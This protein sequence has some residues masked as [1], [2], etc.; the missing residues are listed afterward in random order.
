[1][2][3]EPQLSQG[4]PERALHSSKDDALTGLANQVLLLARLERALVRGRQSKGTVA[5][6][7]ADLDHF[8]TINDV[9]GHTVGDELLSAVAERLTGLIR[10]GDTV[11]RLSGAEFVILCEDLD[12]GSQAGLIATRLVAA[13]A[14]PFKLSAVE[15]EISASVGVAVASA[16]ESAPEQLLRDA[17]IARDQA[18]RKGGGHHHVIDLREPGLAEHRA[19]VQ[20]DLRDAVAATNRESDASRSSGPPMGASS[21]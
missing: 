19:R 14:V 12:E 5:V 2:A 21:A 16:D 18:K 7:F 11:T 15:V 6:L 20:L 1:M 8:K 10:A 9:H 3:S 4:T 13:V 17:Y